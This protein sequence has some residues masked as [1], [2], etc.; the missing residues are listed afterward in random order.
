VSEDTLGEEQSASSPEQG[1]G[2]DKLR[3]ER[4]AQ[5]LSLDQVS[6]YLKLT[7][8]QIEAIEKGDL[9]ALPGAAFS[10]GFVRNYARFLKLDPAVFVA[11]VDEA[12][13]QHAT[14]GLPTEMYSANLGRM[15]GSG[16]SR[17]TA[18]P[19]LAFVVIL[20]GVAVA[21]WYYHW[22]ESREEA[23]LLANSEQS[24]AAAG[25]PQIAASQPSAASAP[26]AASAVVVAGSEPSGAQSDN[27][28]SQ[29]APFV[30]QSQV[31]TAVSQP[32]AR[33]SQSGVA[34]V[35][36]SSPV[37]AQSG[38]PKPVQLPAQSASQPVA[39]QSAVPGSAQSVAPGMARIVL[40]FDGNSWVDV[41]D[42]NGKSVFS[43]LNQA[44]SVQEVQGAAPFSLT[45]GNAPQVKLTW[46]GRPVDLTPYTKGDVARLTVQ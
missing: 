23:E 12:E 32:V 39:R 7:A 34:A 16:N 9:S 36:Q 17:L 13:G 15:P 37:V 41:R 44:G 29:S 5:G 1:T 38:V 4:E 35:H 40:A 33:T 21:G 28:A 18:V 14:N 27:L 31:V 26:V 42:A 30:G 11:L 25:Y 19:I 43:R 24:E 22:F 46:K 45:I 2:W 8:R 3:A 20:V 6:A 10:R